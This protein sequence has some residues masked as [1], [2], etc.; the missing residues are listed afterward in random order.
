MNRILIH[1]PMVR[2]GEYDIFSEQNNAGLLRYV[3]EKCSGVCPN[4]GNRLWF[5]GLIS[6]IDS[7]DNHLEYFSPSMS[8]DYINSNFD[9]IIAPMANIFAMAFQSLLDSLAERFRGIKIPVYVIACGVQADS[10][11]QLDSLCKNLKTSATG[12]ISSV[13]NT[14]G[15]FALRGYFTKEFF[16]RLG[17]SSA[18]VTGCPSMYQLGRNLRIPEEKVSQSRF[19]PLL[20]GNPRDYPDLMRR[21]ENA[22]FFDQSV[23]FQELWD[24]NCF[25]NYAD[26]AQCLKQLIKKYGFDTASYILS[27]RIKLI[28]GMN[29]W[30]EYL[31]HEKF[32]LS[33]GSRIHGS[34]MPILAGIPAIL[35]SRDARTREMADF[36]KIPCVAPDA[37]KRYDSLYE[38]YCDMDYSA[39]NDGFGARFDAYQDFLQRYGIVEHINT[40]NRFFRPLEDVPPVS[41]NR[42]RRAE[43]CNALER[44]RAYWIGYDRLIGLKRKIVSAIR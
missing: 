19:R 15:E 12:F 17:F 11:D 35:E 20:N 44:Q 3:N 18:V 40:H 16:E 29:H 30:R 14:G 22:E 4:L 32:T 10:Y 23:Y 25:V 8:K 5:Q 37:Y 6:E 31:I 1:I 38:L 2:H 28:P 42:E 41:V 24:T 36:F 26:E 34:I 7:P 39:F 27:D 9:F 33:Y 13:Y 21:Y 43:L